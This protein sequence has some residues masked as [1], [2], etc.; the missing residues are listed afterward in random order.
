MALIKSQLRNSGRPIRLSNTKFIRWLTYA[1]NDTKAEVIA[2]G[3]FND[4]RADLSV[5]SIIEAEVDCD[6][7]QDS[8]K[9]RVATVPSS[10]NVTVTDITPADAT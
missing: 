2:A 6:G 7:T 5:G 1:T 8:V 4:V 3:Y 9:M 10:G